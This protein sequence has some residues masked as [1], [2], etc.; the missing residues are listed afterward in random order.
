MAVTCCVLGY[1]SLIN[2]GSNIQIYSPFTLD[3]SGIFTGGGDVSTLSHEMAEAIN[4]PNVV[5]PTPAWGALG[6]QPNCQTNL[7]TGDALSPGFASP[8]NEFVVTGNGLTYHLQEQAY[9]SWFFGGTSLGTA[10]GKYSNNNTFNGY[11]KPCP[12]GGTN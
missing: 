1:H 4:D 11:A 3:T 10:P 6:Q 5:N 12:P 8:T 9:F 2:V 7:E